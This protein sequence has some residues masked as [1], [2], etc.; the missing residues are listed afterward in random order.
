[1]SETSD[2]L[3]DSE[4]DEIDYGPSDSNVVQTEENSVFNFN[5]KEES[6]LAKIYGDKLYRNGL[7]PENKDHV[8][9]SLA[10]EV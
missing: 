5:V 9:H 2:L 3:T 4:T 1:M 7:T 6:S 10:K 8:M